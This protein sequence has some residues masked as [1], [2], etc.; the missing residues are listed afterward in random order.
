MAI[1]DSNYAYFSEEVNQVHSDAVAYVLRIF[2]HGCG[3]TRTDSITHSNVVNNGRDRYSS[4]DHS[5]KNLR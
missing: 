3:G 4:R 1:E 5:E 2:E